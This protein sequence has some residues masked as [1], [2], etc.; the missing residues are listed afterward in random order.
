MI[1]YLIEYFFLTIFGIVLAFMALS[2]RRLAYK[3]E[4]NSTLLKIIFWGFVLVFVC[5][6]LYLAGFLIHSDISEY[7]HGLDCASVRFGYINKSGKVIIPFQYITAGPF[8]HGYAFVKSDSNSFWIDSLGDRAQNQDRRYVSNPESRDLN[9][10]IMN[11]CDF[12]TYMKHKQGEIEIVD[13]ASE[14]LCVTKFLRYKYSSNKGYRYLDYLY[15]FRDTTG[16]IVIP[17]VFLAAYSFHEGLA[18]VIDTMGSSMG[19]RIGFIDHSGH[20]AISPDYVYAE[21][22][23]EGKA[24][25]S[26]VTRK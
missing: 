16:K 18:I 11:E 21:D 14:G 17:F 19:S 22:F 2:I 23:S 25:V 3:S 10:R 7:E 24:A 5:P 12:D 4:K 6:F 15:G 13:S 8:E 9:D 1:H 20:Y 26:K